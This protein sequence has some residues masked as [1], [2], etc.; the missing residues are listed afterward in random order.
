MTRSSQIFFF[1]FGVKFIFLCYSHYLW[2]L[3]AQKLLE[4]KKRKRK[5]KKSLSSKSLF[6]LKIC[7]HWAF[8][9]KFL[10]EKKNCDQ[11]LWQHVEY[12]KCFPS[13]QVSH[14]R[15]KN[16]LTSSEFE[17]IKKS[18]NFVSRCEDATSHSGF[19]PVPQLADINKS[20]FQIFFLLSIIGPVSVSAKREGPGF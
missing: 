1:F 9:R 18:G 15:N 11:F 16:S 3:V 6:F 17:D 10:Q 4:R 5:K 19:V 7:N 13:K 2:L 14:F 8:Y 20:L 12:E